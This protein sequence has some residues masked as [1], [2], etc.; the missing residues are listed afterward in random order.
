M[1]DNTSPLKRAIPV[2]H[3]VRG[4]I[5]MVAVLAIGAAFAERRYGIA[6]AGSVF[7]V[8][9]VPLGYWAWR[10]RKSLTDHSS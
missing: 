3:L 9:A 4:L 7:L 2:R 10:L 1:P 8:L 5:A 6:V